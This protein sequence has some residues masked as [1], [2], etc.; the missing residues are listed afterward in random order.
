MPSLFGTR[1]T[2]GRNTAAVAWVERAVA[3]YE[4]SGCPKALLYFIATNTCFRLWR[5]FHMCIAAMAKSIRYCRSSVDKA[6]R[7][8]RDHKLIAYDGQV[9]VG[10]SRPVAV[11][12]L[13]GTPECPLPE[14][15]VEAREAVR[16]EALGQAPEWEPEEALTCAFTHRTKKAGPAVYATPQGDGPSS[17][18]SQEEAA[19][20]YRPAEPVKTGPTAQQQGWDGVTV[21]RA[22]HLWGARRLAVRLLEARAA[23]VARGGVVGSQEGCVGV[24]VGVEDGS[25]VRCSVS[26]IAVTYCQ[27]ATEG[28]SMTPFIETALFNIPAA[29]RPLKPNTTQEF[30]VFWA[31]YP[32]KTGKGAARKAFLGALA[33]T[34]ATTIIEA[35]TAYSHNCQAIGKET[36]FTPHP[37]TW[38]NQ[39]RWDDDLEPAPQVRSRVQDAFAQNM[40]LV[41]HY[42]Q[43]EIAAGGEQK[44]IGW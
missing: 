19:A 8:L 24:G 42:R 31:H 18:S 28:A 39:E 7:V 23:R 30:E 41:E 26:N 40:A 37:A 9:H 10:K 5:K 17:T 15:V 38:L 6:L 33:K 21:R 43:Q 1:S 4:L 3:R 44:A 27:P 20:S 14:W 29:P 32:R 35:V 22:S 13:S 2:L 25:A 12:R 34:D 16:E 36:Q 11:Y